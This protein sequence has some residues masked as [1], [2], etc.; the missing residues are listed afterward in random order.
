MRTRLLALLLVPAIA[1]AGKPDAA[2]A[3]R[4]KDISAASAVGDVACTA[5]SVQGQVSPFVVDWSDVHR[6]DLETGLGAGVVVVKYGCDGF[7]VLPACTLAGSYAYTGISPKS[8]VVEMKDAASVQANFGS[9]VSPVKFDAAFQQGRALNLAYMMVGTQSTT[10]S[11]V[12][13]ADLTGSCEGATHFVHRAYLGAFAMDSAAMGAARAAVDV[14]GYGG[15][16]A[17]ADS[18]RQS[19]QRDGDIAACATATAADEAPKAGCAAMLRV[20]L[21]PL[22]GAAAGAGTV[23]GRGCPTGFV[24]SGDGCA[25]KSEVPHYLCEPGD[26]MECKTQCTAGSTESCGRYAGVL[27]DTY[28]EGLY[29]P[30]AR[31]ADLERDLAPM[32]APLGG[33]CDAGEADACTM[34]ALAALGDSDEL[35]PADGTSWIVAGPALELAC[36]GGEPLACDMVNDVYANGDFEDDALAPVPR[37]PKL[38][39]ALIGQGCEVGS[40]AACLMLAENYLYG[41]SFKEAYSTTE[42]AHRGAALLGDACH[43]AMLDACVIASAAWLAPASCQGHLDWIGKRITDDSALSAF[44]DNNTFCPLTEKLADPAKSLAFATFA[45]GKGH[46]LSCALAERLA[47]AK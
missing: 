36:A 24:Y 43:G 32:R 8:N 13:A 21:L 12:A 29:I 42:R 15:A 33:A 26:L 17:G 5:A 25:R 4:A 16:S 14:L 39:D 11:R 19:Y 23:D 46:E 28:V 2:S 45:C 35:R 20:T 41:A 18:S 6:A 10:V 31:Q 38:A 1:L 37:D 34:V 44:Q 30:E 7:Q 3:L 9:F 22:D 27:L 40:A 47:K